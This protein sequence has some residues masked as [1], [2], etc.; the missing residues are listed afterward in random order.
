MSLTTNTAKSIP[1]QIDWQKPFAIV[2]LEG[3]AYLALFV[4]ALCARF[5]H[6]GALPLQTVEANQMMQAW[7][8]ATSSLPPSALPLATSPILNGLELMTFR[9]FL[10]SEFL[11]RFWVALAGSFVVISP[12]SL[13]RT[14]G[15]VQALA[16]ASALT[17]SSTLFMAS[18][19]VDGGIFLWLGVFTVLCAIHQTESRYRTLTLMTG[20]TLFLGS[21]NLTWG[22]LL[23]AVVA[24]AL[25]G[26]DT[27][28]GLLPDW[29]FT[30]Q[31]ARTGKTSQQFNWQIWLYAA[32]ALVFLST[33]FFTYPS[34]IS[35][36]GNSLASWLAG[37]L[38]GG[39]GFG[40]G[41]AILT[42]YEPLLLLGGVL[43][44]SLTW[45]G[46]TRW[47]R[48][49]TYYTLF[50]FAYLLVYPGIQSGDTLLLTPVLAYWA[51]KPFLMLLPEAETQ[52]VSA[53]DYTTRWIQAI[54]AFALFCALF[55]AYTNLVSFAEYAKNPDFVLDLPA[56]IAKF[57]PATPDIARQFSPALFPIISAVLVLL[58]S[59][60][61][62]LGFGARF[63]NQLNLF[64]IGVVF[65][66]ANIAA[67]WNLA[68][69]PDTQAAELWHESA[70]LSTARLLEPTLSNI[71]LRTVGNQSE[72]DL[73]VGGQYDAR[74]AW[75]IRNFKRVTWLAGGVPTE[76]TP[77][78]RVFLLPND[79]SSEAL[80]NQYMGQSIYLI[81]QRDTTEILS[82][83]GNLRYLL[84]RRA[85][86]ERFSYDVWVSPDAQLFRPEK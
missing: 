31:T 38:G 39:R 2:S 5:L 78:Q 73:G 61:S 10:G 45:R 8:Y 30:F 21:G 25:S 33:A 80:I 50:G 49:L 42:I 17:L 62:Y 66:L 69:H 43:G 85:P 81:G 58:I 70:L 16:F 24:W 48:A 56:E 37:W 68:Q 44:I 59:F 67:G 53:V 40:H 14:L 57:F 51:T 60:L 86:I 20:L 63:G 71:S 82:I 65:A 84:F 28:S 7:H 27:H 83:G 23:L 36:I 18:R 1:A 79:V 64:L 47:E 34:G 19:T 29:L 77:T 15:R 9:V 35:V 12:F 32:L 52:P 76:G 22:F 6:L 54:L 11:A 41:W 74:I 3:L 26:W 46:E 4:I 13:R 75:L 55:F 72:L